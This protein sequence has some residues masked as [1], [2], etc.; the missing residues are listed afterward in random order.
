MIYVLKSGRVVERGTHE[1]VYRGEG[2]YKE[3][4][5]A[6]ARSLN[7]GKISDTIEKKV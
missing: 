2:V 4:F 1:E 5:D 3:I 7:V 6:A